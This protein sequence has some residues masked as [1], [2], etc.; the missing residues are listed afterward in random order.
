MHASFYCQKQTIPNWSG[1]FSIVEEQLQ[2]DISNVIYLPSINQAPTELSTIEEIIKQVKIKSERLS[3]TEVALV[4]GHAIYSKFLEVLTLHDDTVAMS[5]INLRMGDFHIACVFIEVIGKWFPDS[6]LSD[7]IIEAKVLGPN[8]TE[9]ALHRKHYNY[10][11]TALKLVFEAFTRAKIDTCTK[12]AQTAGKGSTWDKFL[13]SQMFQNGCKLQNN[14]TFSQCID[15]ISPVT[16]PMEVFDSLILDSEKYGLNSALWM[17]LLKMIQTLL[18]FQKSIKTGDWPLYL[19]SLAAVTMV[20]CIW[21]SELLEAIKIL[22]VHPE[23]AQRNSSK[24]IS[25]ICVR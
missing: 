24:N 12:W 17:T 23:E 7:P 21:S 11:I 19:Q 3:L 1:F 2:Q 25:R 9:R 5:M 10:S 22:S 4:A 15:N 13:E 8:T 16:D 18:N 20:S 14:E 6:D